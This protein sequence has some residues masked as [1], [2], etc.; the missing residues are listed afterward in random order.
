MTTY[1]VPRASDEK[2]PFRF[3]LSS[4]LFATVFI[5]IVFGWALDR[6]RLT[7]RLTKDR[8]RHERQIDRLYLALTTWKEAATLQ[9]LYVECDRKN[10]VEFSRHLQSG[11]VSTVA[12][13]YAYRNEIDDSDLEETAQVNAR[14][15]IALLEITDRDDFRSK[16]LELG[17]NEDSLLPMFNPSQRDYEQFYAFLLEE[18][19]NGS[20]LLVE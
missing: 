6:T 12:S 14:K 13:L 8:L 20:D 17:F 9:Q 3:K 19:S 10:S 16:L 18:K 2:R 15:S 5:A 4:L 11:L 7:S 1:S